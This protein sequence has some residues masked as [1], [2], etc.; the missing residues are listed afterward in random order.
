VHS[1]WVKIKK[2]Q[3]GQVSQA[4]QVALHRDLRNSLLKTVMGFG[5][6]VFKG[7]GGAFQQC[8]RKRFIIEAHP[9]HTG[10]EG[11]IP[12]SEGDAL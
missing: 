12:M 9:A 5:N 2:G 8:Y 4:A 3:P 7:E 1:K 6:Q 11:S 10:S